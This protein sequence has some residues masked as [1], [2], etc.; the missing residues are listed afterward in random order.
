MATRGLDD[1][2]K[3]WDIRNTKFPIHDWKDL[4][5]LSAKTNITLS[6]D[7][8]LILTGTSVKKGTGFGF[9]KAFDVGTGE[10]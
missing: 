8:K 7:E 3:L 4:T 5:N 6:P 9:L 2:M 10:E 1:S